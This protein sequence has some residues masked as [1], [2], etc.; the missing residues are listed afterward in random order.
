MEPSA[1]EL[2]TALLKVLADPNGRRLAWV[3]NSGGYFHQELQKM[4]GDRRRVQP[5]A[6]NQAVWSLIQQG[7]AYMDFSGDRSNDW[8]LRLTEAGEAAADEET[9]G[10]DNP[11]LFFERLKRKVPDASDIVMQYAHEAIIAYRNL[12]DLASTVMIGVASEAAFL[13]TARAFDKWLGGSPDAAGQKLRKVLNDPRTQIKSIFDAF[14][15]AFESNNATIPHRLRDG[16]E[17]DFLAVFT[18]LRIYRNDA[19]HPTKTVIEREDV[20][21]HLRMLPRYLRR[22]YDHRNFFDPKHVPQP[23]T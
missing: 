17:T 19:G 1:V 5:R 22:L 15:A 6:A 2:Q 14:R 11:D 10:P 18:L 16:I 3:T 23:S 8:F 4:F 21:N 13:E 9:A 12:C 20:S 7:L